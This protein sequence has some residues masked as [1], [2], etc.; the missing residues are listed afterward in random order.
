MNSLTTIAGRKV[1]RTLNNMF[2]DG[3]AA[4]KEDQPKQSTVTP[5]TSIDLL[6][7]EVLDDEPKTPSRSFPVTGCS[8]DQMKWLEECVRQLVEQKRCGGILTLE[9]LY[10]YLEPLVVTDDDHPNLYEFVYQACILNADREQLKFVLSK[11]PCTETRE[12]LCGYFDTS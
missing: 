12:Q 3:I 1:M 10:E 8:Y 4:Q 2:L 11:N 7:H 5:S 6:C 9:D